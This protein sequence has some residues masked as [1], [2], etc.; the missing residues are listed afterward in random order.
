MQLAG[1]LVGG[2]LGPGDLAAPP[3]RELRDRGIAYHAN[4]GS[5]GRTA[6]MTPISWSSD[7]VPSPGPWG[8]VTASMMVAGGG[9]G[10]TLSHRQPALGEP[11]RINDPAGTNGAGACRPTS[12]ITA[13]GYR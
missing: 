5:S 7:S 1:Q 11:V 9:T 10:G 4:P 13:P 2:E 3:G 12:R 8:P 6:A